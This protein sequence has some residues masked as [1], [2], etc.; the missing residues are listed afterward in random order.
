MLYVGEALRGP[1]R[2]AVLT[3][4]ARALHRE[5]PQPWVIDD[6]L[7]LELAGPDGLVLLDR[8]R[9]EVPRPHLLAFSRWVCVRTRFPEDLVERAAASGVGQYVILGAGLDSFAYRRRDLLDRLRVFEVD[10]PATQA[11][12]RQRLAEFG[13]A[14]PAGLVFAPVDFERQTL[15][16]GLE[17][18]EFAF[19]DQAVFS[20]LGVT[21]Y[22]TLD[23]IQAT[24]ATMAQCRAGTRVVL[25]YNQPPDIL[26]SDDA[27]ITAAMAGLAAKMGEPFISRFRFAEMVRLLHQAGFSEITDFGPDEARAAY[28]AGRP[29]VEIAGAQRIIAATVGPARPAGEDGTYRSA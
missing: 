11:W 25:T 14:A 2:T 20:W 1:S 4:A 15:R 12:K 27:Q 28:F 24:L 17:Q 3:A 29:D 19:G 10:H 26:T 7:A 23:A 16:E 8:L 18:A 6:H 5:E 21:M 13:V 22:L 9:A